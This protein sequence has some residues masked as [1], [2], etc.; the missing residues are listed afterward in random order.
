MPRLGN[1][2]SLKYWK[3]SVD[4]QGKNGETGQRVDLVVQSS[5]LQGAVGRA[6]RQARKTIK[7]RFVECTVNAYLATKEAESIDV[8]Q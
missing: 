6:A 8:T 5:N 7:G 2:Q 1:G 4:F 3:C